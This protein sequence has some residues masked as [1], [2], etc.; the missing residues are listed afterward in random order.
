MAQDSSPDA[1][2]LEPVVYGPR[3]RVVARP[4]TP[5]SREEICERY[6]SRVAI[7][8][9]QVHEKLPTDSEFS[10]EDLASHGAIG[11]LEAIERYDASRNIQFNTFAEY[12][13]RGAMMDALR[14]S[15]SFSRY[16]RDLARRIHDA[17]T[18]LIGEEGSAPDPD[19]V[20]ERLGMD[21]ETYFHALHQ[22]A[23]V[24]FVSIH[25]PL[26]NG[27]DEGRS[28]SEVLAGADGQEVH[29]ELNRQNAQR[30]LLDALAAL[31]ERKRECIELYYVQG[32]G[33]A[34]IA[35]RF[36][37]TSARISQVL[38][39]AREDLKKALEGRV[40][41]E[42]FG[43]GDPLASLRRPEPPPMV[44]R[45]PEQ[46]QRLR[47]HLVTEL[48]A[49]PEPGRGAMVLYYGRSMT[50]REVAAAMEVPTMRVIELLTLSRAILREKLAPLGSLDDILAP[51]HQ[52]E[53]P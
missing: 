33:L 53:G 49:L 51:A 8:A 29:R 19:Q 40:E 32:L 23:P 9:R 5:G 41:L 38:S 39:A 16:R 15:D 1:E 25:E 35:E 4:A 31:P 28:L 34:A 42:E 13:I 48:K 46:I 20:A 24:C 22:T 11:L 3:G 18:A 37:L 2:P 52:G 27:A 44:A 7:I 36:Q 30:A 47:Q 21:R 26:A 17:T 12:R 43:E 6:R 14:Q 50:L 10:V 45:S